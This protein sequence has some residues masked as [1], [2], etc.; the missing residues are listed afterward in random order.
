MAK[1]GTINHER[2]IFEIKDFEAIPAKDVNV[3]V[4]SHYFE[5]SEKLQD[6]VFNLDDSKERLEHVKSIIKKA[7]LSLKNGGLMYVYSIP[8]WLPHIAGILEEISDNNSHFLF[9]YWIS[10][11]IDNEQEINSQLRPSH[12]GLLMYL[13]SKKTSNPSSFHLN[14]KEIRIPYENCKSCGK[15]LRDWGGKKHLINPIGACVSDVWKDFN[16]IKINNNIIPEQILNRIYDLTER[17]KKY[18]K[19]EFKFIHFIESPQKI[20]ISAKKNENVE[21]N[22]GKITETINEQYN[23]VIQGDSIKILKKLHKDYPNGLFNLAFADPPYNLT[24]EYINYSD[25]KKDEAYIDW[26]NKWLYWMYKTLLPGGSLLVLNLPKWAI[27]HAKFLSKYMYLKNWIVWDAMSTPAGK[28]MPAHYAL[29]YMV[30]PNGTNTINYI[31]KNKFDNSKK[32][33]IHNFVYPID[34]PYYCLRQSCI[35]NRYEEDDKDLVELNDVWW[36]IPRIKHKKYR[37]GA[38]PC[39]L[40]IKLMERIIKLFTNEGEFILDSFSG[41]GTTAMVSKMHGRNYFA[42]DI[43]PVY[44]NISEK[45][46]KEMQ[47][48]L[49]GYYTVNHSPVK[50]KSNGGITKKEIEIGYIEL[51][52]QNKRIYDFDEV[53]DIYSDLAEKIKKKGTNFKTLQKMA[54]R[55]LESYN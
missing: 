9:K 38:H 42:I 41:T 17:T 49:D 1:D 11:D 33:Y 14:T 31:D 24:K 21:I 5:H 40:P 7:F 53:R 35:N 55:R 13:K 54:R 28:I 32:S 16:R 36:D 43:D 20:I 44:V 37:D 39:Q 6:R 27:H 22:T 30:K 26:C 4:L 3:I 15:N 29:I 25:D 23:K 8:K 34:A 52:K 12:Q 51:C 19:Q 48:T 50:M 47:S 18:P 46:L 45:N 10:L 2:N